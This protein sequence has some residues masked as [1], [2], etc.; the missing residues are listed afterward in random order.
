M[1]I[2]PESPQQVRRAFL[3][4]RMKP[5]IPLCFNSIFANSEIYRPPGRFPPNR[6]PLRLPP[7]PG[8]PVFENPPGL[9]DPPGLENPPGFANP[10]GLSGLLKPP[11]L[12]LPPGLEPPPGLAPKAGLVLPESG[13]APP[14]LA[15]AGLGLPA[16]GRAPILPARAL[17]RESHFP[18]LLFESRSRPVPTRRRPAPF[19]APRAIRPRHP[20]R[21]ASRAPVRVSSAAKPFRWSLARL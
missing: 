10:P 12:V 5:G 17:G 16:P 9:E 19:F 3:S 4:L 6:E 21:L 7:P 18:A 13:R 14:G 15:P 8:L 11:G 1:K 20:S 2:N